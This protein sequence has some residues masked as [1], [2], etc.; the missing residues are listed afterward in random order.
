MFNETISK[1][2][3]YASA[4]WLAPRFSK[5]KVT[6]PENNKKSFATVLNMWLVYGLPAILSL[7]ILVKYLQI[8]PYL[9]QRADI[10]VNAFFVGLVGIGIF[11][12][13]V[14]AKALTHKLAQRTAP[15][16]IS[17]LN[18]I[19]TGQT[20]SISLG[21][22]DEHLLSDGYV[23][24]TYLSQE[25][26]AKHKTEIEKIKR[27]HAEQQIVVYIL[28]YRIPYMVQLDDY[29]FCY[30]IQNRSLR[31]L[32]V[33]RDNTDHSMLSKLV[34][35]HKLGELAPFEEVEENCEIIK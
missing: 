23:L 31:L 18:Y 20:N 10:Y 27:D 24:L 26:K 9:R 33:V 30:V 3:V 32:G 1:R 13:G 14:S 21:T 15:D 34:Q 6:T 11:L 35:S 12:L 17:E 8:Y 22:M 19:R 29:I 7:A 4:L 16:F 25:D 28:P 2:R 5:I